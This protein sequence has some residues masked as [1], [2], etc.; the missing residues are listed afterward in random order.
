MSSVAPASTA[1]RDGLRRFVARRV[2]PDNVDDLVQ[3]ILLRM[4]EHA[5]ELR[6]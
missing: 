1:L 4:H 6:D 5:S 2:R 3:D